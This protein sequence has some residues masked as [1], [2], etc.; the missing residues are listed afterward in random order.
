MLYTM[1]VYYATRKMVNT[2]HYL[3]ATLIPHVKSFEMHVQIRA[4]ACALTKELLSV[5]FG[6]I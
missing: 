3:T 4:M 5:A 2:I 1:L 6:T